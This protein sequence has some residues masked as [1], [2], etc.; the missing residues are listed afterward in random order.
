M[1]VEYIKEYKN[2]TKVLLDHS[3]LLLNKNNEIYYNDVLK[4][5]NL[6]YSTNSKTILKIKIS[7]ITISDEMLKLYNEIIKKYKLNKDLFDI[8]NFDFDNLYE[9]SNKDVIFIAKTITNNLLF[10]INYCLKETKKNN[11]KIYSIIMSS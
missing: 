6:L 1:D 7:R 4:C 5:L 2:D 3:I 9:K 8:D 10:K 11:K